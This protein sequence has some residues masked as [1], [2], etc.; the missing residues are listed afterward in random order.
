MFFNEMGHLSYSCPKNSLGA[1]QPPSKKKSKKKIQ[2]QQQPQQSSQLEENK[3]A[4]IFLDDS[5]IDED[6]ALDTLASAIAYQQNFTSNDTS[7]N[8]T[9]HKRYR[10]STYFSDEEDVLD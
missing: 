9:T 10:Q 2:K 7:S 6:P 1:R 3:K 4:N 5:D 8:Q